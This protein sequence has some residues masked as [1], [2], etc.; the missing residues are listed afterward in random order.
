[1]R[2]AARRLAP[3]PRLREGQGGETGNSRSMLRARRT[4]YRCSGMCALQGR[5]SR[6]LATVSYSYEMLNNLTLSICQ[7][8][9]LAQ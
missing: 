6:Q 1:M 4:A 7:Q 2:C 3:L 9:P 5:A 8:H